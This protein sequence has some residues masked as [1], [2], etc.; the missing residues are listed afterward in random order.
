MHLDISKIEAGV[1]KLSQDDVDLSVLADNAI[2]EYGVT[3]KEKKQ[4]VKRE[5]D[6][7]LLKVKGDSDRIAQV[8]VNLLNNAIKYTPKDGVITVRTK[9][10]KDHVRFEIE[11]TGPGMD[12][13]NTKIIF[14]KFERIKGVK[15]EGTGLGLSIAKD[16]VL[17]H[18]GK[19]WVET[20]LGK[21]TNFIFTL[22]AK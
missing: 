21:G 13:E 8:I 9:N 3:F 19:I 11:D 4:T 10:E 20:E 16:L 22:P 12:Q 6:K 2:N 14:D 17:L 18:G 5:Y 7:T 15:E 1:I